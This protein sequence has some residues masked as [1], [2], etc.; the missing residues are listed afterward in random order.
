MNPTLRLEIIKHIYSKL[1]IIPSTFINFDQTKS[2]L[3]KDFILEQKISFEGNDG[4][5]YEYNVYGATL[6]I[7]KHEIHVLALNENEEYTVLIKFPNTERYGLYAIIEQDFTYQQYLS[8]AAHSIISVSLNS[9]DWMECNTEIQSNL[10]SSLEKLKNFNVTW[11]KCENKEC[12]NDLLSFIDF[13]DEY[14][15]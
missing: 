11:K 4:N 3:S 2:L 5:N 9:K 10:L 7:D 14:Y 1:M 12:F 8:L 13:R 6:Q 15:R